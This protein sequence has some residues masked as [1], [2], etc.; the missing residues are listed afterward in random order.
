M[1]ASTSRINIE[2]LSS[3]FSIKAVEILEK[4]DMMKYKIPSGEV[5]NIPLLEV[6]AE[7]KK[8]ILL[9]SG[10]SSWKELDKF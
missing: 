5:T 2:F 9:S 8:P 7:T 3:P 4:I 10:M 6:I 1:A